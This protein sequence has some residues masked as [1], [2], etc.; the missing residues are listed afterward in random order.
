MVIH[1]GDTSSRTRI[2]NQSTTRITSNPF[3]RQRLPES[4]RPS[5]SSGENSDGKKTELC[6]PICLEN[7]DEVR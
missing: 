7:I 2:S 3:K 6:C 5:T 1:I 4:E